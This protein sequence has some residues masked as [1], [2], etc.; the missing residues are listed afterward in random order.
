M[1]GETRK[2]R[3]YTWADRVP[4][5]RRWLTCAL[6]V[7]APLGACAQM[8]RSVGPDGRV[9]FSDTPP[10]QDNA[11]QTQQLGKA[12]PT[13]LSS[14][15]LDT[16]M[17]NATLGAAI[18]LT[19][20]AG[21]VDRMT[22]ICS[23]QDSAVADPVRQARLRWQ[24]NHAPLLGVKDRIL[25]DLLP[26]ERRDVINGPQAQAELDRVAGPLAAANP[27]EKTA[28]CRRMPQQIASSGMNLYNS[29]EVV[30]LFTTYNR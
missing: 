30:K 5:G 27:E 7:L 13:R 25:T 4:A 22:Q 15:E 23:S 21:V 20:L 1:P 6:L 16:F 14:G 29:P 11:R 18:K 2:N 9:T 3:A 12:A 17:R 24:E 26:P 10:T 8:Y 19:V 28:F